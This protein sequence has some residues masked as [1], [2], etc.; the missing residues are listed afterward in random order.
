MNFINLTPHAIT[1]KT[2]DINV[3]VQPSGMLAR[4]G[5]DSAE[6][7]TVAGIP[8]ITRKMG[9]VDFD[10]VTR[11]SGAMLL[12]SSMVLDAIPTDH[13]LAA[14]CFAPDT[15]ATAER[16]DKGHIVSVCQLVSK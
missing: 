2:A 15:G 13:A 16:N 10:G 3:T 14:F 8:V 5:T 11:T 1:I 9:A 6:A 7:G 12:V 4:V